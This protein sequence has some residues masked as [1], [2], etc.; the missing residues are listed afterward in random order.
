MLGVPDVLLENREDLEPNAATR[1]THR[2][3]YYYYLHCSA[4]S[5][6]CFGGTRLVLVTL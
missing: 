3:I 6:A 1:I 4:V 5:L 2:N